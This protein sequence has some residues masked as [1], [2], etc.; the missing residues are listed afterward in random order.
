M[1]I[2]DLKAENGQ[3]INFEEDKK[4]FEA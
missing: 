3:S 4:F 1:F 2:S